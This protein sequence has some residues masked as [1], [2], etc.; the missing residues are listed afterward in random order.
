MWAISK[1]DYTLFEKLVSMKQHEVYY[2]MLK[3]LRNK[4]PVDKVISNG[5]SIVA[6]G[7]IPIALVAHLDTIYS[8]PIFDLFYDKNKTTFWSPDGLGADDR[9]GVFAII[10]I[11]QMGLRPGIILTTGEEA[12]GIGAT[13]LVKS[14]CP[15]PNLKFMIELDRQG[16]ND[17]VY[18]SCECDTFEYFITSY[19]F[20]TQSGSFS[21]ISILMPAWNI[22]GVNLS[23]GY[24]NEH[25]YSE[26]LNIKHTFRTIQKVREIL[27]TKDIPTF[28][29]KNYYS[30]WSANHKC[31]ACGRSCFD[32]EIFPVI[33]TNKKK[34]NYCS[35]CII[36][37]NIGWCE[38]CGEAF[39]TSDPANDRYC[40]KCRGEKVIVSGN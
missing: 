35:T 27:L 32:Y 29:Y 34:I 20:K 18:Y 3:Y 36:D 16:Y 33:G 15:I 10:K 25:S 39:I 24:Y 5:T 31:H 28:E 19:G 40:Y 13:E 17:A 4:Y 8:L 1:K 14:E 2:S 9:A 37:N 38:E 6:I 7:D 23:V 26:Y 22:C 21:D 12:G 11:I 30:F